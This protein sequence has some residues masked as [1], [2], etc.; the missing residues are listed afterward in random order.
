MCLARPRLS[1]NTVVV[2]GI[3]ADE[4]KSKDAMAEEK[5]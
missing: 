2:R 1:E 5:E 4:I 3:K